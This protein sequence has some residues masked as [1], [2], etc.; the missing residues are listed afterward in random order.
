MIIQSLARLIFNIINLATM[1]LSL[2][3]MPTNLLEVIDQF[4]EYIIS[5]L[6]I[7][8]AYCN[9]N[10]V[11]FLFK[12]IISVDITIMSYRFIMWVLKKVPF[13]SITD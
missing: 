8:A 11:W 4:S 2:P 5:S 1:G 13:L 6:G 9:L 7:V 12:M 10:Y 3:T